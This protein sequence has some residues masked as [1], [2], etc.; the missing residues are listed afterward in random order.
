[1]EGALAAAVAGARVVAL[2]APSAAPE[3]A[4]TATGA[5][6]GSGSLG[7]VAAKLP[8]GLFTILGLAGRCGVLEHAASASRVRATSE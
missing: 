2:A 5:A 7:A 8:R 3:V 4:D 6:L 1:M